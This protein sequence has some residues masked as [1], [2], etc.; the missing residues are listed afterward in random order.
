MIKSKKEIN[1]LIVFVVVQFRFFDFEY[2]DL[3]E[4][5]FDLIDF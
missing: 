4:L 3:V 5:I 2:F 1:L